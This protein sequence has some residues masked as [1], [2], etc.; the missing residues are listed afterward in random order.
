MPWR[1]CAAGPQRPVWAGS[2]RSSTNP[3]W[4]VAMHTTNTKPLFFFHRWL[5]VEVLITTG[6]YLLLGAPEPSHRLT[7]HDPKVPGLPFR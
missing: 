3:G 6:V 5:V 2:F 4:Y 1:A 7:T